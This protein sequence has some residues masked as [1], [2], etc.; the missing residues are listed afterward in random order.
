MKKI[1]IDYPLQL[2]NI[3]NTMSFNKNKTIIA[4]SSSLKNVLYPNDV[5]CL[6]IN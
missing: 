4:G 5:D 1:T 2:L 3:V 6:E